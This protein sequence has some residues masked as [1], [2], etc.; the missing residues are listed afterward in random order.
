MIIQS[1]KLLLQYAFFCNLYLFGNINPAY[2][3]HREGNKERAKWRNCA[4]YFKEIDINVVCILQIIFIKVVRWVCARSSVYLLLHP[5]KRLMEFKFAK[6]K[7][8]VNEDSRLIFKAY[9]TR[10]VESFCHGVLRPMD[11][12][13]CFHSCRVGNIDDHSWSFFSLALACLFSTPFCLN[14]FFP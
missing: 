6:K 11:T 9:P 4:K 14:L 10:A 12:N 13:L 2:N 1:Q 8:W 3:K 5:K 7:A